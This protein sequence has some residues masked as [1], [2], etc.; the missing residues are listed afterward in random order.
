MDRPNLERALAKGFEMRISCRN[1]KQSYSVQKIATK[2]KIKWVSGA[3]KR[4]YVCFYIRKVKDC[5]VMCYDGHDHPTYRAEYDK[6][7]KVIL[8][9]E[10]AE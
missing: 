1:I 2:H 8:V 5:L 7:E 3:E 10:V 6:F 9:E 4:D